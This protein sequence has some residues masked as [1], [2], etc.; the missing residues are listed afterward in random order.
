M[1]T[2]LMEMN[3]EYAVYDFLC[4]RV[5]IKFGVE[6]VC[7]DCDVGAA[8]CVMRGG[9]VAKIGT[10]SLLTARPTFLKR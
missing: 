4:G 2:L 6:Y 7:C 1:A 3:D 10:L 5:Y 9:V 8:F